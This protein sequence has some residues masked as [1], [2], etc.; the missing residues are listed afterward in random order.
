MQ[1]SK[2]TKKVSFK[3]PRYT[4]HRNNSSTILLSLLTKRLF[5]HI[6][7]NYN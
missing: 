4:V 5:F 6:Q 7:L 1:H 3:I 2:G